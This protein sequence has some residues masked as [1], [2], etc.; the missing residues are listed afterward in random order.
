ML[1][2]G[3]G[4]AA[5]VRLTAVGL[6]LRLV[7]AW[8]GL[9]LRIILNSLRAS[10]APSP[11]SNGLFNGPETSSPESAAQSTLLPFDHTPPLLK[12]DSWQHRMQIVLRILPTRVGSGAILVNGCTIAHR[13]L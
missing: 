10:A 12:A 9:L 1:K 6:N 8:L 7:L 13:A 11:R 4:D 5:I 2:F 3:E